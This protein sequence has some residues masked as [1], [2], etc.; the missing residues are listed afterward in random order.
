MESS[1]SPRS[2]LSLED[3]D[4]I[5][6]SVKNWGR[7]G[8]EDER[9]TLNYIT[10]QHI[11]AAAGLV[12]AGK[13]V[14]LA[15][16]IRTDPDPENPWPALHHMTL[17][18]DPEMHQSV[19]DDPDGADEPRWNQ[20]F[21]GMN[22]HGESHS[23]IDALC[24]CLYRGRLYNDISV[25]SVTS[26]G[27]ERGG[28]GVAEHGIATRGVLLDIPRLRG[29]PWLEPGTA[30]FVEELEAAEAQAGLRVDQGD[31]FL[32]R[33]GQG[34][35]RVELGAW[36]SWDHSSNVHPTT[37]VWLHDR[38]VAVFGSDGNSETNP[39]PIKGSRSPNHAL[40]IAAM[41][42]HLM[43]NLELEDLAT[44]CEQEGRWEFQCVIA[45]LR[46]RRATGSPINPIA[47]F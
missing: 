25:A 6:E 41:G 40:A 24:H 8:A 15:I 22:Y 16:P 19:R 33:T 9:G 32:L 20:D 14:S 18:G 26:R 27:A 2:R 39:G 42:M 23:H 44:V 5:F 35:R 37:M 10:P 31:V 46:L 30:I 47:I 13:T 36:P 11:R 17:T 45:P 1:R 3:L 4:R 43:D 12:R 34:R 29:V 7:W 21:I 38:R 28:M